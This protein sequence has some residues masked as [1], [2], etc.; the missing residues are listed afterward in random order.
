MALLGAEQRLTDRLLGVLPRSEANR[1]RKQLKCPGQLRL[2]D[3]EDARNSLMLLAQELA[4]AG[5]L[6]LPEMAESI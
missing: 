1:V 2:Q 6:R 4:D 5:Q 3:V